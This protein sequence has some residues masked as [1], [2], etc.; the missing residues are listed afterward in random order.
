MFVYSRA[1]TQP[2]YMYIYRR[3]GGI[4]ACMRRFV[5]ENDVDDTIYRCL[6]AKGIQM[7]AQMN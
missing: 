7:F 6:Y 3:E 1:E 5:C 2:V 4:Y